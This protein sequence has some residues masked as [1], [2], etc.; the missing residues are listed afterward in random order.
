MSSVKGIVPS[1]LILIFCAGCSITGPASADMATETLPTVDMAGVSAPSEAS[2]TAYG[3]VAPEVSAPESAT[4]QPAMAPQ[5]EEA[6]KVWSG[7]FELAL[8]ATG[9]NSRNKGLD[10]KVE[11]NA[12]WKGDRLLTYARI[13]WT[14]SYDNDTRDKTRDRN[15]QTAG[16]KY[17]HDLTERLYLFGKEDL[18]KDEDQDLKLRT[19]TQGGA[20]YKI[21]DEEAHKLSADAGVGYETNNYYNSENSDYTIGTAAEKWKWK[22]DESWSLVESVEFILNLKDYDDDF[23][24]VSKVDL[25]NQLSKN[26]FFSFGF[27]HRY[28]A[29]PAFDED[30]N[31]KKKRQDWLV[32]LKLGWTF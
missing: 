30:T 23:R 16:A 31:D 7:L 25:R 2:V 13:E 1:L 12:D 15:R 5:D 27:E 32:S 19:T 29:E 6:E 24:T 20:G 11:V 8:S 10:A 21:L 14:E 3:S 9:G 22:I 28:H 26:L 17:E 4:P 18:E